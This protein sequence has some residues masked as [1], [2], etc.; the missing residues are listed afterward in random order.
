MARLAW[1]ERMA[2]GVPE[3]DRQHQR[4]LEL[5]NELEDA[6]A[7]GG[8]QR[9]VRPLLADLSSYARYH[10]STEQNLMRLHHKPGYDEHVVA[11]DEFTAKVE[12]LRK[13]LETETAETTAVDTGRFLRS[14]IV[15][16]VLVADKMVWAPATRD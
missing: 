7:R 4:L 3:I 1:S 8:S 6:L 16:H 5:L 2:I 12:E 13:M 10:F 11:H 9:F 15:R 14:W